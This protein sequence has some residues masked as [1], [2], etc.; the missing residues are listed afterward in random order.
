[1]APVVYFS[2]CF[3]LRGVFKVRVDKPLSW[4]QE[5]TLPAAP[6][7]SEEYGSPV[8]V[9]KERDRGILRV[10]PLKPCARGK[11]C[12]EDFHEA[13]PAK[14]TH[15]LRAVLQKGSSSPVSQT[16]IPGGEL[17]VPGVGG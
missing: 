6:G 9:G 16:E 7:D 14:T 4:E 15:K 2:G 13:Q 1:M 17:L 8:L 10:E 12:K 3:G 11:K 5:A